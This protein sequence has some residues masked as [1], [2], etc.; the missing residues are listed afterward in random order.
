ME[1]STLSV[2]VESPPLSCLLTFTHATA[3][4][5]LHLYTRKALYTCPAFVTNA[6]DNNYTN[7]FEAVSGE[8]EEVG[9]VVG[10]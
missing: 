8:S 1:N 10:L 5:Y 7:W 4:A 9:A 2:K 3:S 6:C